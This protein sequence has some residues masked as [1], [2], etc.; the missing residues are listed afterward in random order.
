[1]DQNQD[2]AKPDWIKVKAPI[3]KEYKTTYDI[4]KKSGL[5]TVCEE[6]ACP[7]IGECWSKQHVT[8][9]ILGSVCTRACRFCNVKTGR[10]DQLD[11]HLQEPGRGLHPN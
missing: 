5:N 4:V 6:A 11:P 10:P 7:N 1:M 8:V 2:I 9:M 3:S